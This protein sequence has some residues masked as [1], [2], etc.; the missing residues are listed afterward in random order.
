MGFRIKVPEFEIELSDAWG[1]DIEHIK[2]SLPKHY[3]EFRH[4]LEDNAPKDG[5]IILL[6]DSRS[7]SSSVDLVWDNGEGK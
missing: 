4:F 6:G 5:H 2:E 3:R 1:T 7:F